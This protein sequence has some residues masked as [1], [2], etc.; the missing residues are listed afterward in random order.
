MDAHA[1]APKISSLRELCFQYVAKNIHNLE[2][3]LNFPDIIGEELWEHVQTS[4]RLSICSQDAINVVKLFA[5]AYKEA[6]LSVLNV[7]GRHAG[8]ENCL[9]SILLMNHLQELNLAECKLGDD[10]PLV[11]NIFSTFQR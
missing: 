8:L 6:A 7:R 4:P 2:S 3:L 1:G 9:D 11:V 10:H 5:S